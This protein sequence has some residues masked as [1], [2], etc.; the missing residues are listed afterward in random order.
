M[1]SRS[2]DVRPS[3]HRAEPSTNPRP[4]LAPVLV[5]VAAA[6]AAVVGVLVGF[7]A[8]GLVMAAVLALT[9]ITR[10]VLPAGSPLVLVV[11]SRGVDVTTAAVLAVGVAVLAL[12][13]PA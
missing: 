4:A 2:P 8:A 11:R 13:A 9:A 6:L 7:R 12:T 3:T 1:S 10:A 5:V